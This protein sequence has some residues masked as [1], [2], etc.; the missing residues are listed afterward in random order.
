MYNSYRSV[1]R[2]AALLIIVAIVFSTITITYASPTIPQIFRVGLSY[3]NALTNNFTIKSDGGVK[4]SLKSTS[5]YVELFD[6]IPATGLKIRKDSYYNIINYKE[7]EIT[8][9]AGTQYTGEVIGSYHIQVGEVYAD[10]N[11]AKLVLDRVAASTPSAYLAYE[12]GW[13]VW[14]QLYLDEEACLKQ[15]GV[16]KAVLPDLNFSVIAPNNKRVQMFDASTGKLLYIINAEQEIKFDPIPVQS[17]VPIIQYNTL[18]YRG[19]IYIRRIVTGPVNVANELPFEQYLYGIAEMPSSWHMEALKAQAVAARN[20]ALYNLGKH[21]N[22]GFDI[23]NGTHCQAYRGFTQENIR[24]I[25]AVNETV[26]KLVLYNDKLIPTY[27]HSSSGGRTENSENV[28]TYALP[29]IR[30]VDDSYG[31]GSSNDNWVKNI[32]KATIKSKLLAN[33]ID[34]GEII[35]IVPLEISVN[36]RVIKLEIRGTKGNQILLKEKVRAIIGYSDIKST[37]YTI[38]TDAD[39]F[40]KDS[41]SSKPELV[42]PSNMYVLSANGVAKL[43]NSTNKVFIK[44]QSTVA[45]SSIIPQYYAFTGKG[46]GHGLGMSQYGAKGMAEAGFNYIQILEHYYT[47]AKVK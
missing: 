28:W 25:Q 12:Q 19:N 15:I 35:D 32:D 1:R 7:T 42:R 23:C 6:Y 33:K 39:L 37:W 20:Y 24:T 2:F 46:W 22:D 4:L 36:G 43:D 14:A 38:S 13:R 3:S 10:I 11:S 40:V 41:T 30:A 18:K 21:T 29:Y 9:V 47:G 17:T 5:G 26:G 16:L 45:S 8:Y 34:V 31:L 44:N 27:Y